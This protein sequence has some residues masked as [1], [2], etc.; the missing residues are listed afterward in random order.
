MSCALI[1]RP[2]NWVCQSLELTR[3]SRHVRVHHAEKDKE[4]SQLREVLNQRT[5]GMGKTRRKRANTGP[6]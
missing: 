1:Y 4:D 5:E 2:V 6:N 3:E